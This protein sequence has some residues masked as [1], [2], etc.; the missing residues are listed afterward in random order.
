MCAAGVF[1]ACPSDIAP[2][3]RFRFDGKKHAAGAP[4]LILRFLLTLL[5][6]RRFLEPSDFQ[7][8]IFL[9]A[10]LFLTPLIPPPC[11]RTG[12]DL[13]EQTPL[14]RVGPPAE[15]AP[16]YVSLAPQESS[17]VIGEVLASPADSPCNPISAPLNKAVP[18]DLQTVCPGGPA[19][20][21]PGSASGASAH[22]PSSAYGSNVALRVGPYCQIRVD[23]DPSRH[24]VPDSLLRQVARCSLM[25]STARISINGRRCTRSC[26]GHAG[27]LEGV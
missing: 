18:A 21:S 13:G 9:A 4:G 7:R 2:Q 10:V 20:Q 16:A 14:G 8:G 5:F 6:Q 15:V 26:A 23:L 22:R 25:R 17:Y 12:P 11:S 1:E 3:V 24:R 27:V 19:A